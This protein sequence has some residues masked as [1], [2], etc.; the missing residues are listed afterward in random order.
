[1]RLDERS[2][3]PRVARVVGRALTRHGVNAVL[4]G[5]A[6]ASLH[7]RGSYSSA[8][9]DY[10]LANDPG[11]ET[12]D[13]AM[14]SVGFAREGD[15]YRHPRTP[16][17]VEF[18]KGPLAIGEDTRIRP[19]RYRSAHGDLLALSPTDSCRDRLAAFY[20]WRDRQSLKAAVAIARRNRVSFRVISRWS[21]DEGM[22]E[23]Y[24]E[25]LQELRRRG[26][27]RSKGD[28]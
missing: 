21:R 13:E 10:V 7:T 15:R 11:L 6:C 1:M 20:H 12:L 16:F 23:R 22:A 17:Y 2:T 27:G 28:A 19:R 3:L 25:F 18:P 9:L 8:D 4:T 5:G 14:R 24:Q 26:V